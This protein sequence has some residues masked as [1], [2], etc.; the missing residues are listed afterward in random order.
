MEES[1]NS[2]TTAY[3]RAEKAALRLIARAEQCTN[4]LIRKLERRKHDPA[5]ISEVISMLTKANLLNDSRFA[6][7]WL[8]SRLRFARTPRRLLSSLC[9]R[10]IDHD[11][12]Q[13]AL[14]TALD[15]ETENSLLARFVKKHA[16]KAGGKKGEKTE[17][18]KRSLKFLLRGEGFSTAAIGQYLEEQ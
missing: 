7:L 16:R 13:A 14:Q 15:P 12:A 3:L 1:E 2:T 4:G 11:D 18:I 10:G 17:D 6:S 8:R 9:A 5:S